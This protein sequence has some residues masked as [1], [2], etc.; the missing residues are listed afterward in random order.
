MTLA[1]KNPLQ[2]GR[3][4]Q[5]LFGAMLPRF[6]AWAGENRDAV[7]VVSTQSFDSDPPRTW[8][9]FEVRAPFQ[10]DWPQAELGFPTLAGEDVESSDDTVQKPPP[11]PPF[12]LPS[13][14]SPGGIAALV[15]VA[16]GAL[17]LG[18]LLG[19]RR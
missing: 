17:I 13:I 12:E 5:D 6:E 4:W 14:D 19:G 18:L 10:V 9:L 16:A 15:G 2:P 11:E 1:R 8:V 3:Y 7:D